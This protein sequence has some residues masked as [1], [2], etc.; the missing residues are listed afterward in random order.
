MNKRIFIKSLIAFILVLSAVLSF[1]GISSK[2]ATASKVGW[3]SID[4]GSLTVR[5]GPGTSYKKV[6][7]LKNNVSVTVY[8]QTKN[9]WSQIG[10]QKK[11]AYV[12][13][14]HLRMYSFLQDKTKI[15]T[16]KSEGKYHKTQ[17]IGKHYGWDE[18]SSEDGSYIMKE[19]SKGLYIGW[20]QS[21]YFTELSYP[22]KVGKQWADWEI[23]KKIT[24]INGTLTTPAG[25]FKNVVTVKSSDGYTTYYAPNIGFIKSVS[26]GLTMSEL[27][28]LKKR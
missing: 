19:D 7:S 14:Q 10:Y 22:L 23:R 28:S 12:A 2:A 24:S 3:V 17:Y 1:N 15:Y 6:G 11:K 26:N 5:S 27:T 13:S 9:G 25:T 4:S 16:Y 8:S 20:P 18:W 21:D